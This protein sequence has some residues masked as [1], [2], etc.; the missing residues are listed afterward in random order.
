M[1]KYIK[2]RLKYDFH[3]DEIA[4]LQKLYFLRNIAAHNSGFI[5]P[6]QRSFLPAEVAIHEDQIEIPKDYLDDAIGRTI[7]VVRRMDRYLVDN[8]NVPKSRKALFGDVSEVNTE[9]QP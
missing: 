8:W 9:Q 6:S 1:T 3:S 4:L 5:R 2:S 7:A